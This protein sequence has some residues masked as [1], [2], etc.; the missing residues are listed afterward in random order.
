MLPVFYEKVEKI[1]R[2]FCTFSTL[3]TA[4]TLVCE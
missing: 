2:Q 1:Q 4:R 3:N